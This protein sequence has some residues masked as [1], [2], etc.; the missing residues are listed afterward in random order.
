MQEKKIHQNRKQDH[1]ETD[2]PQHRSAVVSNEV[3]D[4][5]QFNGQ[6]TQKEEEHH[7]VQRVGLKNRG[8]FGKEDACEHG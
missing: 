1:L 6:K 8:R 5:V 2:Q 4:V 3:R 7:E